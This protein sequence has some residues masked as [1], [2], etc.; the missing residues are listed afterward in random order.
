VQATE[1]QQITGGP[2]T[3]PWPATTIATKIL[4]QPPSANLSAL[5]PTFTPYC[6]FVHV[7]V[8]ACVC[9][10]LNF[11]PFTNGSIALG[12]SHTHFLLCCL[13]SQIEFLPPDP[14]INL[15]TQSSC[16]SRVGQNPIYAPF[17]TKYLMIS[18]PKIP[19][20]HRIYMVLANPVLF[21]ASHQ[22]CH[23][24]RHQKPWSAALEASSAAAAARTAAVVTAADPA[25][26]HRLPAQNAAAAA[27]AAAAARTAAAAGIDAGRGAG[28]PCSSMERARERPRPAA[29]KQHTHTHTMSNTHTHTH[30][31]SNTYTHTHTMSNTHTHIHTP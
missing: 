5:T 3:P 28:P 7:C 24:H 14:T 27:A 4:S 20:M 22:A 30:T 21:S 1:L 26:L 31:M 17:M 23:Q 8:C 11:F 12:P 15:P 18:L 10:C 9:V 29:N 16:F 19:Y 25:G 6:V 13:H 2:Q